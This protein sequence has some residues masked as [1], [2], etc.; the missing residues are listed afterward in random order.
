MEIIFD[1]DDLE[2]LIKNMP[3]EGKAAARPKSEARVRPMQAAAAA[4]S[5][6]RVRPQMSQETLP[7]ETPSPEFGPAPVFSGQPDEEGSFVPHAGRQVRLGDA[8]SLRKDKPAF[9]EML[10]RS[11]IATPASLDRLLAEVRDDGTMVLRDADSCTDPNVFREAAE[12]KRSL[13]GRTPREKPPILQRAVGLLSR[14]EH[15][16]R[17]LR[18]KLLRGLQPG[19]TVQMVEEALDKLEKRGYLSD[20]R[21]AQLKS[22]LSAPR[23][24]N[25]RIARELRA[26]GVSEEV[27]RGA[28]E[29]I[30]EPEELRAYRVW[31]KRYDEIPK[32]RKERDRQIRYLMYRGFS[33]SA[34]MAVIRGSV[35]PE[36]EE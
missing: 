25:Q 20:E 4:S 23:L 14:R 13:S 6:K 21:Y 8:N 2:P 26:K 36:D 22:M 33:M 5:E 34:V 3:T 15:S 12:K 16:R 17:E 30:E 10:Q 32:D 35:H 9:A 31:A 27:V 29:R 11:N 24:G 28:L 19:E 7:F 18:Q 1:E